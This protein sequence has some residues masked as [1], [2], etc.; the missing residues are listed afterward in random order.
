MA[1]CAKC[2][3]VV[4]DSSAFCEVCGQ[5]IDTDRQFGS[6]YV[7]PNPTTRE[8]SVQLCNLLASKYATYDKLKEDIKDAEFQV[9]KMEVS[10]NPPRYWFFRFYWPF[11]IIA[12][13]ACFI[14]TL[15]VGLLTLASGESEADVYAFSEIA[16][17]LSIPV[18][19]VIG[20]PIAKARQN[21]ANDRLA[22]NDMMTASKA[23][24]LR[25]Q[26][27]DMKRKQSDLSDELQVY[28]DLIPMNMRNQKSIL[29]IKRAL[30]ISQAQTI[31][32]A[33][34]IVKNPR[35]M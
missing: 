10:S 16:G 12:A 3:A 5:A 21:K 9:K 2:G 14:S 8:E 32:E 33:I 23:N 13:A 30:D 35:G 7:S 27:A 29:R 25:A 18:V 26:I 20:I 28:K 31:E 24:Q 17:Y 11:F 6:S 19:L 34:E 15:V 1:F 22:Q 4:T